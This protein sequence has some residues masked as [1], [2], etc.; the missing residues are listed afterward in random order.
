MR[1]E[2]SARV[3]QKVEGVLQNVLASDRKRHAPGPPSIPTWAG[4]RPGIER[5]IAR[6][7][8]KSAFFRT[9][10]DWRGGLR[11]AILPAARRGGAEAVHWGKIATIPAI[12]LLLVLFASGTFHHRSRQPVSHPA[13]VASARASIQVNFQPEGDGAQV[14]YFRDSGEGFDVCMGQN[15][16]RRFGW[17]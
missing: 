5:D 12:G 8:R 14:G 7:G 16:E 9:L 6:R 15:G 17:R 11:V 2:K 13:T 4:V 1:S 3:H 10:D